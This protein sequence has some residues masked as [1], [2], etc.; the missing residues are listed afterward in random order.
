MILPSG[1]DAAT[2]LAELTAGSED[3][4]ADLMNQECQKL[5]LKHTHFT[6]CVGLHDPQLYS[7]P[8]DMAYIFQ[9]AM[10]NP[11][12]AKV[13]ST[14]TYTTSSSN[15]HAS[16]ITLNSG[17]FSKFN[18]SILNGCTLIG[19]KTGFTDEAQNCLVTMIEKNG[20][21]YVIVTGGLTDKAGTGVEHCTIMDNY[22]P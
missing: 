19:G 6:N 8:E 16:G 2:A 7:T 22:A 12:C 15:K 13:L 18:D 4:F 17:A 11:I 9:Y 5:G 10:H 21:H 1:A 14:Q 3:A 20:R